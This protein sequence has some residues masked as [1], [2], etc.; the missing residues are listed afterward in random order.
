MSNKQLSWLDFHG[1]QDPDMP[2]LT[3]V[4]RQEMQ[5]MFKSLRPKNLP[6]LKGTIIIMG[7]GGDI[8][9]GSDF[10]DFYTPP[11]L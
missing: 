3:A 1:G 4:E 6:A 5:A 9:A 8:E 11:E 10:K 7:T 2:Y